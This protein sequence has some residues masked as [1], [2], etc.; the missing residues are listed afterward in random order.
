[1]TKR[2]ENQLKL[3]TMA[4]QAKK[5]HKTIGDGNL[6]RRPTQKDARTTK[7]GREILIT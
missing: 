7:A 6:N 5:I 1:M 4:Y 2:S 3:I